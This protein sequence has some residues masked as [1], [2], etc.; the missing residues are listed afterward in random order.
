MRVPLAPAFRSLPLAH[1]GYHDRAAGR[2]ENSRAAFRAAVA[3]G[4]GIELDV[5]LAAD[6]QAVVFHDDQLDRLTA[7]TG[8][9]LSYTTAE[10]DRIRLL[11]SDETIPALT[12]VLELVGGRVPVLIEIKDRAGALAPTDGRLET[13]VAAALAGYPGPVAV[14]S[15]NPD[16]VARMARLAPLIP[17]GLTTEC[18]DPAQWAPLSPALCARL[19]EIPDYDPTLSSFISHKAADLSYPRVGDLKAQGAAILCWTVRSPQAE[20][21]ARLVAQNITFEGYK[22]LIPA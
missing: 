16:C 10:L 1:R 19:R 18:F 2:P 22:A 7:R 12:T 13:A 6:G 15:F 4:Y 8:P 3:A 20:A 14:M 9:V 5:Q 17:R 21:R 11:G